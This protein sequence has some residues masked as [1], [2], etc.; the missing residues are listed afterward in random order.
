MKM[1]RT[2]GGVEY[3]DLKLGDGPIAERG[4]K[5]EVRYSL[6]LNRGDPVQENQHYSFRVGKRR[7]IPGL[8][9]GVEGMRVGGERR[10]RV[11]P[12]LAYR[13]QAIPGVVPV[14]AVLEFQ[15]TLLRV[16]RDDPSPQR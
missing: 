10:L 7:A 8:E 9:L 2:R 11:G 12:H 5:V 16:D 4:A 1:K 14:R 13:D 6:F 3:E 15:V